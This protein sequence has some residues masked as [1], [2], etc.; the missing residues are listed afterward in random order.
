MHNL[1]E[2]FGLLK[3]APELREMYKNIN[4]AEYSLMIVLSYDLYSYTRRSEDLI[5]FVEKKL[6][7]KWKIGARTLN[8]NPVVKMEVIQRDMAGRDLE[9]LMEASKNEVAKESV[10]DV[11]I[12][13]MH[14]F[15]DDHTEKTMMIVV[16]ET[17]VDGSCRLEDMHLI[18][19]RG[20]NLCVVAKEGVLSDEFADFLRGPRCIVVEYVS[21]SEFAK[22]LIDA[23]ERIKN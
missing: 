22:A 13:S 21:D 10:Y 3:D 12:N 23:Y 19:D 5:S 6:R 7:H 16:E 17:G 14:G 8:P 4:S 1:L 2:K 20:I 18:V 15:Q 11:A 9:H